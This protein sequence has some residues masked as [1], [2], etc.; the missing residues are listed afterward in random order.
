MQHV[1]SNGCTGSIY[2][3]HHNPEVWEDPE[4]FD[5][6]RFDDENPTGYV[7]FCVLPIP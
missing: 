3:I 2:G 4:K 7:V 5:P 6:Y 1:G